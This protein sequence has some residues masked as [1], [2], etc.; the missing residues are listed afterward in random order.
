MIES[1]NNNNENI[2]SPHLTNEDLH[3]EYSLR[4]ST[5]KEF[6]GQDDYTFLKTLEELNN[7][8]LTRQQCDRIRDLSCGRLQ[9]VN[10]YKN[11]YNKKI[12]RVGRKLSSV[13]SGCSR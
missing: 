3:E 11:L 5:F 10:R 7:L 2:T 1:F 12:E 4:P 9:R 6:I 13:S 8:A